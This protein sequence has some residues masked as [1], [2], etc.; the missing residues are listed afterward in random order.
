MK[1]KSSAVDE[2]EGVGADEAEMVPV[3]MTP[4]ATQAAAVQNVIPNHAAILT[5]TTRIGRADH[6]RAAVE[7]VGEIAM[8]A[9]MM[10]TTEIHAKNDHATRIFPLGKIPWTYSWTPTS[11]TTRNPVAVVDEADRVAVVDEDATKTNPGSPS[12]VNFDRKT[13]STAMDP[14]EN[15]IGSR[16][17]RSRKRH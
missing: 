12:S 13:L 4:M 6:V 8:K 9:A 7:A 15:R 1:S 14:I 10:T 3:A 16:E 5:K 11:R 2:A 17:N